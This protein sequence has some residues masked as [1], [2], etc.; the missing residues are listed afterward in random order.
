LAKVIE[1]RPNDVNGLFERGYVYL[2]KGDYDRAISDFDEVLRINPQFEKAVRGRAEAMKDKDN[3]TPPV[4]AKSF[5]TTPDEQ[6]SYCLEAS[7]GYAQRL[8]KL[9]ALL[10]D[11]RDKGQAL[12]DGPNVT[13]TDRA[14][15]AAQTTS[16]NDSIASDDAKRKIWDANSRAFVTYAQEHGLF[17]KDPAMIASM[18]A[19][20]HKDQEAVQS[21]YRACLRGCTADDGSCKKTCREKAESSDASMR[22]LHCGEIVGGS[23]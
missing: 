15:V 4:D 10:R 17:T 6:A 7:F 2:K 19:Q 9:L 14:Q 21:T 16:L 5:P 13:L 8:T 11:N 22:M 23:K 3:P 18:S 20:V 12:L 1:A